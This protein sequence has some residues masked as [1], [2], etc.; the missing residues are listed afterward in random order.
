MSRQEEVLGAGAR[1]LDQLEVP[2]MVVGGHAN[3]LWG[4]PRATLD[5][6]VTVLLNESRLDELIGGLDPV[7]TPRIP[8]PAKFVRETRVFRGIIDGRPRVPSSKPRKSRL[9]PA[10]PRP[11]F[12][13]ATEFHPPDALT[14]KIRFDGKSLVRSCTKP[15]A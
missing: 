6:D 7:L 14:L 5:I 8:D 1:L 9:P 11:S 13:D 3:A 10:Y 4:E 15:P 12:N 2:Y